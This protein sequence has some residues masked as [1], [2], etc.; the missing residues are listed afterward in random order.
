MRNKELLSTSL[1]KQ[2]GYY[3]VPNRIYDI[4]LSMGGIAI[5]NYLIS[6]PEDFNP[7]ARV[8]ARTLKISRTTVHKLLKE[9]VDRNLITC[10]EKGG[11]NRVSKYRFNSLKE[12]KYEVTTNIETPSL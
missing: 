11:K 9:L 1:I 4:N 6:R 5:Y 12:W 8:I 2:G 10:I 7:A 3:K